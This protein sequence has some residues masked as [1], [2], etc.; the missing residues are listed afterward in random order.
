MSRFRKTLFSPNT[1][2]ILAVLLTL[3]FFILSGALSILLPAPTPAFYRREFAKNDTLALVRQQA[4]YLSDEKAASY[5]A[6]LSEEELLALMKHTL[7]YCIFLEDD[8]NITVNGERLEVFR[9]DELSHMRDV[10]SV[11]GGGLLLT[12]AGLVLFVLGV[13]YFRIRPRLY[14]SCR[15]VP[16]ITLA[17]LAGLL[18]IVA[19]AAAI[20]FTAAFAVF[21]KIFFAG[22]KWRFG[23]GVMIAMIG[24]IFPD[25]VPIIFVLWIFLLGSFVFVLS[26]VSRA[27][28]G[29]SQDEGRG[30]TL[31]AGSGKAESSDSPNESPASEGPSPEQNR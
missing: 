5:V 13:V 7:R 20:D 10:R 17:V 25:L 6:S 29:A 19:L 22:T 24:D 14:A 27:L 31:P 23:D 18:L 16:Y 1:G 30:Q 15:R 12:L 26:R 11:F 8:L 9:E 21:H 3:G 28:R 2:R 4:A